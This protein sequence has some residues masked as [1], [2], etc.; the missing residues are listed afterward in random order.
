MSLKH[1]LMISMCVSQYIYI[2][3]T[4]K[5]NHNKLLIKIGVNVVHAQID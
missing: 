3:I 5:M 1:G 2:Y 4:L